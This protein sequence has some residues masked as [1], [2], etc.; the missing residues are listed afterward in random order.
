[1]NEIFL[2]ETISISNFELYSLVNREP[3]QVN[4][5]LNDVT[6]T[7]FLSNNTGKDILNKLKTGQILYKCA[8]YKGVAV[9]KA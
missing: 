4:Q 6:V 8:S 2:I 7:R 9:V 1:M 5:N 3:V